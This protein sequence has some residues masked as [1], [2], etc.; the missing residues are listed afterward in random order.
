VGT[1]PTITATNPVDGATNVSTAKT[2]TVTF[3]QAI[4]KSSTFWVELVDSLG[5]PVTYTSYIIGSNMLVIK[6]TSD[7]ATNTTYKLK[8]HT[9][10]VTDLAGN[11]LAGTSI[12]FTIRITKKKINY[13][14]SFFSFFIIK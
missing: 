10:C 12:S 14:L 1:A 6:P 8:L 7:L 13:L 9:G 11:P 3:D 2:L 5:T 4:R